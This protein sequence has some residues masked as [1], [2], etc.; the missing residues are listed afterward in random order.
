MENAVNTLIPLGL[1]AAWRIASSCALLASA[2]CAP[3]APSAHAAPV[4]AAESGTPAKPLTA[5]WLL[6]AG[7]VSKILG[8]ALTA[9]ADLGA[10]EYGNTSCHYYLSG[11]RLGK[12]APRLTV[13]L[14][15]HGYNLMAMS[16]PKAGPATAA[17][18]YA[19]IGDGALL[20]HG[21]LF[22]RKGTH[23]VAMDLRG[24]GDLHH[25]AAQLMDAAKPKLV[26]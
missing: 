25:I 11:K 7:T 17:A 9:S 23:S 19:D 16:L 6:P 22:V 14:D 10:I 15:W 1:R 2:A 12:G 26:E 4:P 21:V 8:E 24:D 13:T 18:P 5:C 3:Q 20:K